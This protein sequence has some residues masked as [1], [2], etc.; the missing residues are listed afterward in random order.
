MVIT[1]PNCS[2]RYLVE[3]IDLSSS[4]RQ[5]QCAACQHTWFYIPTQETADLKQEP[6]ENLTLHSAKAD[7]RAKSALGWVFIAL[8]VLT[9]LMALVIGRHSVMQLWPQTAKAYKVL[10]LHLPENLD[11]LKIE[12]L[13][14]MIE[15]T[16]QGQKVFLTGT[17]INEGSQAHEIKKLTI[18]V[19]GD[20]SHV[21]WFWRLVNRYIYREP[22]NTCIIDQWTYEPSESKIYP[23][24]RLSFE[25]NSRKELQG[26]KS[27]QVKF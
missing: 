18:Y 10:G 6:T 17:I 25:T 19:K 11:D 13:R 27:I 9:V 1:C 14:P 16:P 7:D 23:N 8:S 2:K 12:G 24:E 5:V 15:P 20:C 22:N 3:D 21:N 26:A 4:G